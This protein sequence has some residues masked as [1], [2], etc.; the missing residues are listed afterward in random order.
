M[1]FLFKTLRTG[2]AMDKISFG[3]LV[4]LAGI[5]FGVHFRRVCRLL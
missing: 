1:E 4:H 3:I 5:G 2:V